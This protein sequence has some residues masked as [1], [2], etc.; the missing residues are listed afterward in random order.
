MGKIVWIASY[1]K[2]G[3]TWMRVFIEYLLSGRPEVDLNHFAY[4]GYMASSRRLFDR[5]CGIRAS[6]L[7]DDEIEDL[8]PEVYRTV[9]QRAEER[10][11]LKAHDAYNARLFPADATR[12]AVYLVRNPLDVVVSYAFHVSATPDFDEIVA[13]VCSPSNAMTT[14]SH[15]LGRQLTVKTGDW[16]SHVRG[17]S[18]KP[19]FRGITI[20]YEDLLSDPT[21]GFTR[22]AELIAPDADTHAIERAVSLSGFERLQAFERDRGFL[23]R[24]YRSRVFFRSGRS[25]TWS[26]HLTATQVQRMVDAH[27]AVMQRFGYLDEGGNPIDAPNA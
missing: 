24:G 22:A 5:I 4:A 16:S 23:E 18:D 1:P 6:D 11:F 20:R 15:R 27:G 3:N 10:V 19:P 2:S 14:K 21:A 12:G 7:T 17:W 25:G 13:R 9:S 8:R 26:E